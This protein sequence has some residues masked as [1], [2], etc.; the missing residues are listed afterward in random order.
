MPL[1]HASFATARVIS[2][3][4]KMKRNRKH[5]SCVVN[6]IFLLIMCVQ[7]HYLYT[8]CLEIMFSSGSICNLYADTLSI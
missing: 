8:L 6:Y 3:S 4:A 1:L 2:I 7:M 5:L